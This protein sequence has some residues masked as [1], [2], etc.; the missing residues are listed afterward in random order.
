M[1]VKKRKVLRDAIKEIKNLSNKENQ[2]DK[3]S[4]LLKKITGRYAAENIRYV[5]STLLNKKTM[6]VD[7]DTHKV[8]SVTIPSV[9]DIQS[10]VDE[11]SLDKITTSSNDFKCEEKIDANVMETQVSIT[12]YSDKLTSSQVKSLKCGTRRKQIKVYTG[13]LLG[14][15][16]YQ[17]IGTDNV[18]DKLKSFANN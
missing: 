6:L 15:R 2:G 12:L 4:N 14:E 16:K 17:D 1:I 5:I 11:S 9:R 18:I 8:T 3:K 7:G 13:Y 10:I